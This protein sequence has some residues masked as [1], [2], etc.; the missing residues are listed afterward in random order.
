MVEESRLS[1]P[2]PSMRLLH[3]VGTRP[4][5]MK[6][7]PV[8][9]AVDAW[10]EKLEPGSRSVRIEQRLVHTG[11]HYDAAMSSVFFD[12]LG[13]PAPD[14]Y[15][16]VRSGSHAEQTAKLMMAL[17][18][19]IVAESPT[20]VLVVGDVNSTLAAALVAVKLGIPV[21]HVESGLR[22]GD[23]NMPEEINRIVT[24]RI[25]RLLFTTS[26][27]ASEQLLKEGVPGEWSF[28]VGNAMIDCLETAL[29]LARRRAKAVELRLP[30]RGFTLVTLHRPSNV[31]DPAQMTRMARA[32]SS[33]AERIPVAF[34]VHARTAASLEAAGCLCDL[35]ENPAIR[36]LPPLG[37]V[38]FLSLM[39]DARLVLTDSG[40]IQAETCVVGT[41]CV[42]MRTTTEW[43]ETVEAG[44]NSLVDPYNPEAVVGAVDAA[45]SQP[46]PSAGVRPPLWDGHAA[47]RIVRVIADWALTQAS[48]VGD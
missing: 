28:L 32:L 26:N 5:F 7:A 11:Q 15:L 38:E 35:V 24:D 12:Q 20:L 48:P 41:P 14:V 39:S 46:L 1:G 17:E 3:V 25:S 36:L 37:Y 9:A 42:T 23:R 43:T 4:N 18:P 22:S 31:D 19:H 34:P 2:S 30:L 8:M 27:A 13:L 40:G 29:P 21:A 45:L 44:V 47:E 10:N 33:V 6:I 16:D